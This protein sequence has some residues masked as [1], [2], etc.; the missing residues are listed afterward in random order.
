VCDGTG[1]ESGSWDSC[2]ACEGSG[3]AP[4]AGISRYVWE[5]DARLRP[6]T[7]EVRREFRRGRERRAKQ[8]RREELGALSLAYLRRK[9]PHL[10]PTIDR[11][12]RLIECCVDE[13]VGCGK[14]LGCGQRCNPRLRCASCNGGELRA[15][16]SVLDEMGVGHWLPPEPL[17]TRGTP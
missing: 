1:C 7:E 3:E 13:P 5:N 2:P 6:V 8:A 9:Q 10:A 16:R 12:L 14:N 4:P 15:L 17:P 11:A